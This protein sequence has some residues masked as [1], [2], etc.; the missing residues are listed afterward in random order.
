MEMSNKKWIYTY[1]L[2]RDQYIY[3]RSMTLA[4][5]NREWLL[6]EYKFEKKTIRGE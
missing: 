5:N 4:V 6:K 2:K 1:F 3:F